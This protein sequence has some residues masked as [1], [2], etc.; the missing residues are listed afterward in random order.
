MKKITLIL[1][2][3]SL[4]MG[5]STSYGHDGGHG[6]KLSDTGKHGGVV[7]AVVLASERKLGPKAKLVYKSELVR[8]ANGTVQIYLYSKDMKPLDLKPFKTEGQG[9]LEYRK[10]KKTHEL[11]F[12]L[13]KDSQVFK[14]KAPRSP[15]RPFN[16][17]IRVSQGKQMFLAAF[18]NLD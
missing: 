7:A 2:I 1:S 12:V 6:P 9:T 3:L 10:K 17:D 5:F 11:T 8:L 4:F 14:G 15:K 18:D 13:T 16:M